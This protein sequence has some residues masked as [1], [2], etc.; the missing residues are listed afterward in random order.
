MERVKTLMLLSLVA[1]SGVLTYLLWLEG[2]QYPALPQWLTIHD[3][4]GEDAGFSFVSANE[5]L[6]PERM[7]I[8]HQGSHFIVWMGAELTKRWSD[9]KTILTAAEIVDVDDYRPEKW[10]EEV[11]AF[12][13]S[14]EFVMAGAQPISLWATGMNMLRSDY[15]EEFDRILVAIDDDGIPHVYLRSVY[16]DA[17]YKLKLKVTRQEQASR[18]EVPSV[19]EITQRWMITSW[20]RAEEAAAVL[21]EYLDE[22]PQI[23]KGI[24]VPVGISGTRQFKSISVKPE[25]VANEKWLRLFFK[26]LNV[27]REIEGRDEQI[28]TDGPTALKINSDSGH[29]W[30]FSPAITEVSVTPDQYTALIDKACSFVAAHTPRDSGGPEYARL[31]R[32]SNYGKY[33]DIMIKYYASIAGVPALPFEEVNPAIHIQQS[34]VVTH[35]YERFIYQQIRS[36]EWVAQFPLERAAR[37]L[38]GPNNPMYA[39]EFE[40]QQ[41]F[42]REQAIA[43]SQ[44]FNRHIEAGYVIRDIYLGYFAIPQSGTYIDPHWVLVLTK[45]GQEPVRFYVNL[46]SGHIRRSN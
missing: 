9:L 31:Y 36:G 18:F 20:A 39:T 2:E 34:A 6:Q 17:F 29:L 33:L 8:H 13:Q 22:L 37:M 42:V 11:E 25:D 41:R 4:A 26:N 35:R 30:Y 12:P 32:V 1:V 40:E 10:W 38:I 27:V 15:N 14:I 45:P 43:V 5:L 19:D 24:Y 21:A 23:T 16:N 28:Y 46:L 44:D 3:P 7:V